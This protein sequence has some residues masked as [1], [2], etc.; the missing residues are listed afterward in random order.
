MTAVLAWKDV[1]YRAA[2]NETVDHPAGLVDLTED[3]FAE[4]LDMRAASSY[5]PTSSAIG[6]ACC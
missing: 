4:E 2:L 6:Y 3:M 1:D 5:F